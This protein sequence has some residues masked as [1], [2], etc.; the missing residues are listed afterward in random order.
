MLRIKRIYDEPDRDDGVRILV[1]RLW[2][3]GITKERAALDMWAKDIAPSPDLRVWF[4]HKPERF[5]EFTQRYILELSKNPALEDIKKLV[6]KELQITF[7]Y[8]AR[9]PA[10]NH[11]AVLRDFLQRKD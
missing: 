6:A 3:R 10:V 1:D 11:A 5:A 4:N 9:D 7:L 8:G 2:P